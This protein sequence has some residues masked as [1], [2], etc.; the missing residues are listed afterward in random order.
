MAKG[1]Y[2][3]VN[4]VARKVKQ[5]Y[6]GV[7]NVARK[8]KSGYI[9]VNNVAR[10]FFSGGTPVGSLAVG[11]SVWMNVN[12]V[13]TEF[14]VV[15]QGIPDATMYDSSCDGTWLLMKDI[16]EEKIWDSNTNNYQNSYIHG[17][18][19]GAF[20]GLFDSGIQSVIKKVKIPYRLDSAGYVNGVNDTVASGTSGLSTNIFLLSSREIGWIDSSSAPKDGTCL[21][22]FS[23]T[24][25]SGTDPKRVG[26]YNANTSCWWLRSPFIHSYSPSVWYVYHGG[27]CQIGAYNSK[28]GVRPALIL[29][30]GALI[31][32]NFNVTGDVNG[33]TPDEPEIPDVPESTTTKINLYHEG[34]LH[35]LTYEGDVWVTWGYN[36]G[37]PNGKGILCFN[38]EMIIN[39]ELDD[40][41]GITVSEDYFV[42]GVN[43]IPFGAKAI[44]KAGYTYTF[45]LVYRYNYGSGAE[46][47]GGGI[48]GTVIK[49][50]SLINGDSCELCGGAGN[51][52][53]CPT[54]G[55]AYC[56]N[57]MG[58]TCPY[59]EGLNIE[60]KKTKVI[61]YNSDGSLRG[62]L[63]STS[64]NPMLRLDMNDSGELYLTD[65]VSGDDRGWYYEHWDGRIG[66]FIAINAS[67]PAGLSV[68]D[69][70]DVTSD[71]DLSWD[72]HA[73]MDIPLTPGQTYTYYIY[74]Y[75]E[76]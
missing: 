42:D 2:I 12:G 66:I 65:G 40:L 16:Y 51:V 41:E 64:S 29:A 52:V 60:I 55:L 47:Q 3:G 4:N 27:G 5:Q 54:C 58:E 59:C 30:S 14:L 20:W 61:V 48:D 33:E 76:I 68:Y 18:L 73:F 21:S 7:D 63:I 75:D 56:T 71:G 45:Y 49:Q 17:Y 36:S 32:E 74:G 24:S 23:D 6:I 13:A 25:A 69:D 28:M 70:H 10:Q 19:N 62:S 67:P 11:S 8:V 46:E 72:S 26:Y 31:D 22:Y 39:T 9:G 37:A 44:L 53:T 38:G 43:D 35:D 34:Y 15:H 1:Q 57:C 50:S